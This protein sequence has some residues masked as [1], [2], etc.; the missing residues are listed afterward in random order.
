MNSDH[1]SIR[2]I[3][4][5]NNSL[6]KNFVFKPVTFEEINKL[7]AN[8]DPKKTSQENDIHTNILKENSKPFAKYVYKDINNLFLNSKLPS[9]LKEADVIPIYIHINNSKLPKENYRPVSI[10]PNTS[11]SV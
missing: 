8:L 3:K 5:R 7:L 11:K 2:L 1:P 6:S 4:S 9:Q 10:L